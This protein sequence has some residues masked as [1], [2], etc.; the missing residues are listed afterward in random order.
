MGHG[1]T[2]RAGDDYRTSAH[3][4]DAL[5]DGDAREECHDGVFMEIAVQGTEPPGPANGGGTLLHRDDLRYP[6]DS[7][8]GPYQPACWKY[9]PMIAYSFT[10]D[11][12]RT[13]RLC[14]SAPA[15]SAESCYQGVGKQ[16]VGWMTDVNGVVDVCRKA[17]TA[18]LVSACFEG[19][20]ESYIDDT[21]TPVGAL[22]LCRA[23]PD[24]AK[25]A[26]YA[27]IGA[28]MHLIHATDALV[29][30]DCAPAEPRYVNAC[31]EGATRRTS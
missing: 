7:V 17:A 28:R 14:D 20:A 27:T 25:S 11:L 2:A 5:S 23:A 12:T 24:A 13:V 4:C 3:A 21:W 31:I 18:S 9:Q 15:A 6:C 19:A 1:L 26:C 10:N 29:A 16:A 30:R 22:A 8:A